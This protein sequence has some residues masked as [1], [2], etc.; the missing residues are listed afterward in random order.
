MICSNYKLHIAA[1][2]MLFVLEN[3]NFWYQIYFQGHVFLLSWK[4]TVFFLVHSE[5]SVF[6]FVVRSR[7]QVHLGGKQLSE[8]SELGGSGQGLVTAFCECGDEPCVPH[9]PAICLPSYVNDY[10]HFKDDCIT[11]LITQLIMKPNSL[12]IGCYLQSRI[13][14]FA[15]M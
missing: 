3:L 7:D 12:S 6:K 4:V 1:S 13:F 14:W 2:F 5:N 9:E 8:N 15:R 11:K 10:Q